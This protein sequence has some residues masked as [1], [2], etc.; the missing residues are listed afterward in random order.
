MYVKKIDCKS[1]GWQEVAQVRDK[2]LLICT[3]FRNGGKYAS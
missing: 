2:G 1:V 3:L